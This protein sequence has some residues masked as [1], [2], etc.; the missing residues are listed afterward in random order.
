MLAFVDEIVRR[1][2]GAP[3]SGLRS[4]NFLNNTLNGIWL[5]N[6][7]RNI[8]V[9]VCHWAVESAIQNRP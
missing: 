6:F 1:R 5:P 2:C 7:I 4:P 9:V 3:I 8:Q